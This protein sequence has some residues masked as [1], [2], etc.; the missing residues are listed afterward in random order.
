MK[1]VLADVLLLLDQARRHYLEIDAKATLPG[2][3]RALNEPERRAI[4]F[5]RASIEVLNKAGGLP[6]GWAAATNIDLEIAD[7][8]ASTEW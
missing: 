3:A 7:S 8:E 4:S 2:M 1:L 6:E 5:L